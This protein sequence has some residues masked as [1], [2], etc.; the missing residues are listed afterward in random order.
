MPSGSMRAAP[1]ERVSAQTPDG[2]AA[3]RSTIDVGSPSATPSVSRA[4]P[5]D[6]RWTP[7]P[8]DPTK[9]VSPQV[10]RSDTQPSSENTASPTPAGV[11]R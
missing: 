11:T 5:P 9:R 7:P 10:A 1:A 6:R 2:V 3:S 4:P 8:Y